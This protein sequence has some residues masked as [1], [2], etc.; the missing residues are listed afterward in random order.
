MS[1]LGAEKK[2]TRGKAART[3]LQPIRPR[4]TAI[5]DGGSQGSTR[6]ATLEAVLIRRGKSSD[7]RGDETDGKGR[8]RKKKKK[9]QGWTEDPARGSD[10]RP[11]QDPRSRRS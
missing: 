8:I 10:S 4:T 5:R 9:G 3:V 7:Q 6:K 1:L 2:D 11:D